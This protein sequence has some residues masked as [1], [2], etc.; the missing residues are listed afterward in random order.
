MTRT[1]ITSALPY[2]NGVKHLGNLVGSMLPADVYA[3][4][5]RAKGDE[6]LFICAT[7]E[8]GNFVD[9]HKIF[10]VLLSWV[11][12]RKGWPGAVTRAFNT[13]KMLDRICKKHGRELIEHG[14]GFKYVCDY[15]LEREIVMGG[16]DVDVEGDAH[17]RSFRLNTRFEREVNALPRWEEREGGRD[18]ILPKDS[19][20]A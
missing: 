16:E 13:T 17:G 20:P 4:F 5:R 15:M 19:Y 12:K 18:A 3:R 9:P 7:D 1:L 10:S 8:H 14:I 6:T 11:L 2:I